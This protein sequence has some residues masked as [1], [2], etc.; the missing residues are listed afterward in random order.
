[1]GTRPEAIKLAPVVLA[2]QREPDIECR[3]CV[4]G[5]HRH[6]MDQVLEVFEIVPD[7]DLNLMQHDQTLATLSARAIECLAGYLA[8]DRPDLVLV[9]GD[10]TTT[11]CAALAAF[12]QK[13]PI[14]HVEAGLRTWNMEAPWPE[15][16]NRVLTSRLA[17][18]HFAPTETARQNLL[19]EGI[20]NE[21]IAVTGN[22]VIDALFLALEKVKAAP[23]LI[24]GLPEFLQPRNEGDSRVP[25]LVLITGHRRESFGEGFESICW[26]IA[27]LAR[28]F[29]DVHFVYPVHL[30]P[31]VREPVF[32]I[33]GN[34]PQR[35][36]FQGARP[37]R[38]PSHANGNVH[39][40]EPLLYLEFVGLMARASLILTDSGG[41]QEEAP[42]LGKPVL[43]MRQTT[44]RPEAVTAGTVRLV[45]AD[46]ARIID[47][48][49]RLL[50]DSVTYKEMSK[51]QNPYG[52]G[53]AAERIVRMCKELID[54]GELPHTSGLS[55][56]FGQ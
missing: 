34:T 51:V 53:R 29:P 37:E 39:L 8:A 23:P 42:S 27:D 13:I 54:Q 50:V 11:F 17:T 21:A 48:V 15:E 25:R 56:T 40:I 43:V 7:A 1:M 36:V 14:G 46:R 33:L 6:M 41:I 47:E 22:T 16:A 19:C 55:R 28:S 31:N 26:A 35:E 49:S 30:N 18:L 5:Q 44:E 24:P 4:T 10:T 9:Q 52:D 38:G 12:Y 45:G 3:V 32:R 2:L 20:P